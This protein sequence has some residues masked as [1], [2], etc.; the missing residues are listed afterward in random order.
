[1]SRKGVAL[2]FVIYFVAAVSYGAFNAATIAGAIAY[3]LITYVTSGMCPFTVWAA[4]GF[5][6]AQAKSLFIPWA[7][8]AVL[9]SA[10]SSTEWLNRRPYG[11]L[12]TEGMIAA[13]GSRV[14]PHPR[15][16]C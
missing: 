9:L 5:K 4:R 8:I 16:V 2:L 3:G 7:I 6:A 12:R 1:M 13:E 11:D 14:W 10:T 15:F